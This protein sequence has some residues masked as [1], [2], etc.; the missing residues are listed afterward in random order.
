MGRKKIEHENPDI[1]FNLPMDMGGLGH[2]FNRERYS[3]VC[4]NI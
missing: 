2:L 3:R 4:I 1:N